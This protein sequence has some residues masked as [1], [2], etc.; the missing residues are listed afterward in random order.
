MQKVEVCPCPT[1]NGNK[2]LLLGLKSSLVANRGKNLSEI[3]SLIE[4]LSS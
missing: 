4:I 3:S 1:L 2:L